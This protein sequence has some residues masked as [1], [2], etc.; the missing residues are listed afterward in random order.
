MKN[1]KIC[2]IMFLFS[3]LISGCENTDK[4]S[5]IRAIEYGR[6]GDINSFSLFLQD[7]DPAIRRQAVTAIGRL[8][9]PAFID[10]LVPLLKDASITVR[11]EAI[12]ALGQLFSE[13]A[14]PHLIE[15]LNQSDPEVKS[16]VCEALGKSGGKKA[17]EILDTILDAKDTGVLK[18]AVI[19]AALLGIKG[20]NLD[21]ITEK[22][23]VL[24]GHKDE[25]IRWRCFFALFRINSP[26]SVEYLKKGL[27]DTSPL[28][29][30]Y[31]VRFLSR[32][33][34]KD[35]VP[36]ILALQ[37]D[38]DWRVRVEVL[39][40]VNRIGADMFN[41][42]YEERISDESLHVKKR[43]IQIIGRH[44]IKVAE[45][46]ILEQLDSPE[47]VIAGE[48][49]VTLSKIN[50]DKTAEIIR[51]WS[52]DQNWLK[53]QKCAE[54]LGNLSKDVSVEILKK[55]FRDKDSRIVVTA[56]KSL[57]KI[58]GTD[59]SYYLTE[60]LN[61]H[62]MAVTTTA[63]E[64][65]AKIKYE[66]GLIPFIEEYNKMK[67][68]MDVEPKIAILNMFETCGTQ[69][70]VPFL[71]SVLNEG[72]KNLA[73]AA[74]KVLKKITGED[75]SIMV[76]VNTTEGLFKHPGYSDKK[77]TRVKVA[78]SR[79]SFEI[80][81]F[82]EE[83][84]AASANFLHLAGKGFFNGTL[85]HR[86]APN[87]VV[88][89]ADPRGDGWGGPGYGIRCEINRKKFKRGTIGMPLMGK[90]TGGCQW[91]ICHS[92]QPNLDGKY[93]VY[94]EVSKGMDVVDKLQ[95]GDV[96]ERVEIIKR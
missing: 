42:Y 21:Q 62:D 50:T 60:S 36:G 95:V 7:E 41:S 1:L 39:N 28:V 10:V 93:T 84:P 13:E 91:F 89:G 9:D 5:Q 14:M 87:F 56:M 4:S 72:E 19:A 26:A 59:V 30:I 31:A 94:G 16:A 48:A 15:A 83:A 25:E 66:G 22:I 54:A 33:K 18:E 82:R 38:P 20:N 64:L 55:M 49:L 43:A 63:A 53:R 24:S 80:T 90:D 68:P 17:L 44:K 74:A 73:L 61:R 81:L 78:T 75:H 35:A 37:N 23:G 34:A 57:E 3:V 77:V 12:F 45:K 47:N 27:T 8:Q 40:A 52:E 70:H 46:T 86:S 6:T 29:K 67:N 85:F 32:L 79:G 51:D 71:K 76:P 88:Q 92:P 11:T 96:I 69:K 2:F 58:L 65:T